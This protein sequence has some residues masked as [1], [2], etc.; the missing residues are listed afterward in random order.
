VEPRG[1]S[2]ILLMIDD[3]N[4]IPLS[5]GFL[6][7]S[8]MPKRK[9]DVLS[10]GTRRVRIL[11]TA[12]CVPGI[13]MGHEQL[14]ATCGLVRGTSLKQTGVKSR[15]LSTTET[16]SALAAK[17]CNEAL[18]ASGMSWDDVDCMVAASATM[19]QALPY[20][21]A[22]IH[23]EL[24][25]QRQRTTTFD[26]GAS[27]MSFL[28][29][30]D[31]CGTL[32]DTGRFRQVMIVSSDISTFTTDYS[33]LRTNGIFGDG[34]A[35][36]LIGRA[37]EGEAA[38]FLAARSITLSEGV[39][40]CQIRAGG[41]RFHRRVPNSNGD[42]VFEMNPRPL[43]GL[44]AREMPGFVKS[45][46]DDVGMSMRDIDLVVPHQ[47][48]ALALKHITRMLKIPGDRMV[49]ITSTH[50]NQVGASLPTA[51]HFGLRRADIKR[52]SKLLLLGSGAGV[53]IGGMV[54]VY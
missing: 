25:L 21:A 40:H 11:G 35:A 6:I 16:A 22:M 17:A 39:T 31:I 30:L 15:Y 32:I 12:S 14:D 43:Y 3:G 13:V 47:A 18:A 20:N 4:S 28:T 9:E 53:T 2:L 48:S 38:S 36:C 10:E 29:A 8:G 7:Q 45:L 27:C 34:A 41:S 26:I 54:L 42:A 37:E 33:D 51:L 24:G 49:D 5:V 50:A 52:G 19:D 44:I 1:A 46:L 23:A